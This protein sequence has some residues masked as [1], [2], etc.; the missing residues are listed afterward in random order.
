MH[1]LPLIKLLI[2]ILRKLKFNV[3]SIQRSLRLSLSLSSIVALA[4][5][6]RALLSAIGIELDRYWSGFEGQ[7]VDR[8]IEA[9]L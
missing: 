5:S 9:L 4:L 2:K 3:F 6:N 7:A 1:S 8:W